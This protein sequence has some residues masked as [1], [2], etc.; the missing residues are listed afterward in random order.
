MFSIVG[1]WSIPGYSHALARLLGYSHSSQAAAAEL[2]V[3]SHGSHRVQMHMML[4]L[5]ILVVHADS[6]NT[7]IVVGMS[8]QNC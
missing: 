2:L 3:L 1:D 8:E 6:F 4:G 5:Q 7:D